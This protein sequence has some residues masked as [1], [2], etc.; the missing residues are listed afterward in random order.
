MS[1][2][3][4]N[5][6]KREKEKNKRTKK[7]KKK[8]KREEE[9]ARAPHLGS[10]FVVH[11]TGH[12]SDGEVGQPV[13]SDLSNLQKKRRRRKRKN[14][15][16]KERNAKKRKRRFEGGEALVR[17]GSLRSKKERRKF[18]KILILSRDWRERKKEFFCQRDEEGKEEERRR[19][20]E[21]VIALQQSSTQITFR[22]LF[23]SFLLSFSLSDLCLFP[24]SLEASHHAPRC[25]SGQ[26]MPLLPLSGAP[27]ERGSLMREAFVQRK[28]KNKKEQGVEREGEGETEAF[29]DCP[30]GDTQGKRS[31]GKRNTRGL[32]FF[33]SG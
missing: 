4:E 20:A 8:R 15:R 25:F 22:S 16:K 31:R 30:D 32:T 27:V 6:R 2:K 14:E 24:S 10:W 7:R 33:L 26:A 1:E 11:G 3:R 12:A 17:R 29:E 21:G 5:K 28:E 9:R 19:E 13:P 18:R 23:L